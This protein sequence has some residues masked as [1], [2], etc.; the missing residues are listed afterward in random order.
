M[1]ELILLGP[2]LT[3]V[4][5]ARYTRLDPLELAHR[6]DLLRIG[7]PPLDEAYFGFQ[8][9]QHAVDEKV[10]AVV[11]ALKGHHTDLEIAD[12]MVRPNRALGGS[13]PLRWLREGG[14]HERA[15]DASHASGPRGSSP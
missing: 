7:S 3:R 6:P 11:L 13:S 12:W 5:A 8:F 9:D 14:R 1:H 10:G 2:F 4:D 15:L